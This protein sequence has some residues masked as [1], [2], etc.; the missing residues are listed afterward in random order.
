M[1]E[2][3]VVSTPDNL[4]PQKK[5]DRQAEIFNPGNQ[6]IVSLTKEAQGTM[7]YKAQR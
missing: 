3:Q 5:T 1:K 6:A 7:H 4:R 2:K